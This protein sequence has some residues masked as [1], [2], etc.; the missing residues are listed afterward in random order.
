MTTTTENNESP[1]LRRST[2]SHALK[3][4]FVSV[5]IIS[6]TALCISKK[7]NGS[8]PKHSGVIGGSNITTHIVNLSWAHILLKPCRCL[9]WTTNDRQNAGS[10]QR[11]RGNHGILL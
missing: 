9:R 5:I 2:L 7:G 1:V 11:H 8:A 10:W 4:C 6:I 3:D